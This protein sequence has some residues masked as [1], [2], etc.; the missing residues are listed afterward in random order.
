MLEIKRLSR[1]EARILIEGAVGSSRGVNVPMCIAG[2]R[3][4]YRQM[5]F[6][7]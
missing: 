1:D 4:F 2:G 3:R 5:G 6:E 7:P